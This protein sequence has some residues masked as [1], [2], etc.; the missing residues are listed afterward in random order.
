[1][2]C[3]CV[4]AYVYES[5]TVGVALQVYSI[6][7]GGDIIKFSVPQQCATYA[8]RTVWPGVDFCVQETGRL[9]N[10]FAS[11]LVRTGVKK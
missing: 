6:Q 10:V 3:I 8:G 2:G 9:E 1:M 4:A 11:V 5:C 7:V